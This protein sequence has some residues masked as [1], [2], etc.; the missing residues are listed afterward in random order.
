MIRILVIV[1]L[2]IAGR[3]L[4]VPLLFGRRIGRFAVPY[5]LH[6]PLRHDVLRLILYVSRMDVL[7]LLRA[8]FQS[9]S[10]LVSN[11]V[12]VRL[13]V[14]GMSRLRRRVAPGLY[15]ARVPTFRRRMDRP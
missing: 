12:V 1:L 4:R 13:Q 3:G 2:R 10:D 11:T 15:R 7:A 14:V 6:L 9:L 5:F 8:L